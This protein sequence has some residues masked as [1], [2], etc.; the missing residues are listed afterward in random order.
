MC[1]ASRQVSPVSLKLRLGELSLGEFELHLVV[2]SSAVVE[3]CQGAGIDESLKEIP[4]RASGV[5]FRSRPT[6]GQLPRLT[7]D[8]RGIQYVPRQFDRH[9][10]DLTTSHAAYVGKF[11]S[12]SRST[13][14]RKV[15]RFEKESGGSIDWRRYL[16]AEEFEEFYRLARAISEKTYQEKL[17]DAGLPDDPVSRDEMFDAARSGRMR[18]YLIFLREEAVAYLCCPIR[19]GV[20]TYGYLGYRTEFADLSPGTVLLWLVMED[21]FQEGTHRVF[22]FTE[23]GDRGQHSQK[24]HF[25]TSS[26]RCADVYIFKWSAT[27]LA[28]VLLHAGVEWLSCSIG[29]I[30]EG[31]GL[32]RTVRDWIRKAIR[33]A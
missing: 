3:G 11:S 30:L 2:C 12:K 16:G 27:N 14:R 8:R 32:K 23:G 17:L 10:T 26:V 22:D 7:F 20:V 21:L 6:Q 13:L 4:A 18:G 1:D 9:F 15:H 5:L 29:R 19:D 28:V 31:V 33:A 24:R 25:S